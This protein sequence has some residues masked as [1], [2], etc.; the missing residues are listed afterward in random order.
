M[1]FGHNSNIL[2]YMRSQLIL[3]HIFVLLVP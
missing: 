3:Q 1:P 2:E